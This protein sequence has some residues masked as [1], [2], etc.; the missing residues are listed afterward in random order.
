MKRVPNLKE[1]VQMSSRP[2]VPPP[3]E[4]TRTSVTLP[5]ALWKELEAERDVLNAD[6]PQPEKFS[7]DGFLKLL[8]EWALAEAKEQRKKR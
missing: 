6:R 4:W 5:A 7:R 2:V 1:R 8:L 3:T